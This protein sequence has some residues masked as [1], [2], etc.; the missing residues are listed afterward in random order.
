MTDSSPRPGDRDPGRSPDTAAAD[1]QRLLAAYPALLRG[2]AERM[3]RGD[4]FTLPEPAT[5]AGACTT[6]ARELLLHPERLAEAQARLLTQTASLWQYTFAR[7]LGARAEPPALPH[8]KDRRF[9]AEAWSENPWF[10]ALR[11]GYLLT[12]D[13]LLA[14][15][16]DVTAELPA[17]ERRQ[18]EFYT[19]QLIEALAPSNYPGGNP[20][21]LQEAL[22]T[23][24]A[25]LL[26]GAANLLEDTA[27]GKGQPRI[28][29]A[30]RSAFELGRDIAAT[31]GQ[32]VYQNRL[33][34][35]I[36]YSPATDEVARRP[37]LIVPPW[38]NKYYVLDLV[39]KRSFVRWAVAQGLT[40]FVISWVNPDERYA[41]VGFE[42]YLT[43]GVLEAM[44]AVSEAT[45][46]REMNAVGY[47]IGGTLLACTLAW[48][49]AHGDERIA[50]ATFLTSLMDFSDVGELSVFIDEAQIRGMERH[51][52]SVGYFEGTHLATAFNLL[53]ARELIWGASVNSYLLGREPPAFDL[54]CWNSDST[55]M[56]RR[57]HSFYLRNM[58]LENRLREPGGITLAGVPID[59]RRVRLPAFLLATQRDHIAPWRSCYRSA[60]LLGG[61]RVRFVLGESGHIAGAMNPAGSGKYGYWTNRRLPAQPDEWLAGAA[62]HP[63]SWWPEWRAWLE[64]FGGGTVPARRPGDGALTPIEPAPGSYVRVQVD[65]PTTGNS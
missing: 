57:M 13:E 15:T 34:Q 4:Q 32:V 54:L 5:V 41:E 56:P 55:R 63:G 18:A 60:R 37:L 26:R 3:A 36:Q 65:E 50:S 9:Q 52:A 24:G 25:S 45:G 27:R 19:R 44:D 12:A 43:G 29:Q 40:V 11:R 23:G 20:Q 2:L 6:V 10:D 62:H 1:W 64:R 61:R 30:D 47:C 16:R 58:Y 31:P 7:M 51:M 53:Q 39:A 22:R 35:L 8:A 46:E 14:A 38:I 42:D 17:Q 28:R 48:L 21:V 33:F 59:L 49:A